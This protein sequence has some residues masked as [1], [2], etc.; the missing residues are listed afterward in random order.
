MEPIIISSVYQI[1]MFYSMFR[2]ALNYINTIFLK[3][4]RLLLSKKY[5]HVHYKSTYY[6]VSYI[7]EYFC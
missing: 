7:K 3:P 5:L 6:F 2:M 4:F 1:D